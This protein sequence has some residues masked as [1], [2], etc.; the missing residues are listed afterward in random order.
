MKRRRGASIGYVG[1]AKTRAGN[2]RHRKR[3]GI[4]ATFAKLMWPGKKTIIN[5]SWSLNFSSNTGTRGNA[6]WGFFPV[7]HPKELDVVVDNAAAGANQQDQPGW[8]QSHMINR[9]AKYKLRNNGRHSAKVTAYILWPKKDIPRMTQYD[10]DL[11]EPQPV[12]VVGVANSGTAPPY[13]N[14]PATSPLLF[15]RGFE[16]ST[17]NT[18]QQESQAPFY[19]D[20]SASIYMSTTM[21]H[22]FKI[23]F[24]GEKV[25]APS[26]EWDFHLRAR[27]IKV[28]KAD[29]MLVGLQN[30]TCNLAISDVYAFT[31]TC[32]PLLCIKVTGTPDY[33][34]STG[35]PGTTFISEN[36][37]IN[38]GP[39]SYAVHVVAERKFET[40][41][42]F[43]S[44]AKAI[45]YLGKSFKGPFD[46]SAPGAAGPW[47][48]SGATIQVP[49]SNDEQVQQ[50]LE[51]DAV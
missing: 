4:A 25:L 24:L 48:S 2:K 42:L 28:A 39:G 37:M 1:V 44:T 29:Y 36:N 47:W 51:E 45:N 41:W 49:N 32:G 50:T 15:I 5:E 33:D 31:K 3:G 46:R 17:Q 38:I 34:T 22:N 7:T 9:E 18:Q 23:K 27:D 14:T 6:S 40:Q 11:K 12:D 43:G 13:N 30:S 26:A 16:D 21:T 20:Y 19:N 35:T 10:A 8:L